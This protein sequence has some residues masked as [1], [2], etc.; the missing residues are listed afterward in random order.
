MIS[1][2]DPIVVIGANSF[3]GQDFVDLL[4]ER[5]YRD[6][7]GISRSAE[8]GAL[9]LKYKRH[10]DLAKRFRYH[11]YDLNADKSAILGL[12][13]R[14]RPAAIVNFAAQSEVAPSWEHPEH[15]YQTNTV[16]LALLVNH[17]RRQNY[18]K[19]YLHISSPEVYGTCHGTVLEGAPVKPSTPYASSKAAADALLTVYRKQFQ[20]P[21]VTVRA[22]NVYGARQQL[23]KIIP[24]TVISILSGR[25]VQ[26]HGG[27]VAKKSYIHIR[28]VS[29]GELDVLE[30]GDIGELYHISPTEG[31]AVR[32]VVTR[33]AQVM[34]KELSAVAENIAE[35][36]GQDAAYVIDSTK[37]RKKTGWRPD[38]TLEQGLAEV[39]AWVIDNWDEIKRL[40][41]EYQHKA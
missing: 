2:S 17:L 6:V 32:D 9:F 3:S 8:R 31:V 23:F 14:E 21:L 1:N 33:I 15:W 25:I 36:P 41:H 27:G 26:L 13:D 10:A 38:V 30:R 39:V 4:L 40:P 18:L 35:R 34:G 24:R 22:T 16:A 28:D 7:I 12:F 29:R 19:R 37:L 20:F 11:A 5:G